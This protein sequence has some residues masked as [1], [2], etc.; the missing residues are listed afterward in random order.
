MP[1]G[2]RRR[3]SG[4][5]T[6]N[7]VIFLSCM[8]ASASAA[9]WRDHDLG[10]ARHDVGDGPIEQIGIHMAREIAV[11][12]NPDERA[13]GV[14]RAHTAEAGARHH[15]EHFAQRRILRHQRNFVAAVHDIADANERLAQRAAGMQFA[16]L[17][18]GKSAPFHQR[19]RQRVA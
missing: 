2:T 12:E 6:N 15:H 4:S 19:H 10:I 5:T 7:T 11:G 17:V 1:C 14:E 16:I 9:N 8:V 18:G 13:F 3:S